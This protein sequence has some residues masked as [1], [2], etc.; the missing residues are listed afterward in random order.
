MQRRPPSLDSTCECI[1]SKSRRRLIGAQH[2]N[3]EQDPMFHPGSKRCRLSG[4]HE[5]SPCQPAYNLTSRHASHRLC[6]TT[7]LGIGQVSTPLVVSSLKIDSLSF[8]SFCPLSESIFKNTSVICAVNAS[9]YSLKAFSNS[10]ATGRWSSITVSPL[11]AGTDLRWSG[12]RWKN[13]WG[14]RKPVRNSL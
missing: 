11:M 6:A 3:S 4:G 14:Q 8:L 7:T 1:F 5:A 9:K 12:K 2:V 13:S 10:L